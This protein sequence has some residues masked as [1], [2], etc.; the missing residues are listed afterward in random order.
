MHLSVQG[1]AIGVLILVSSISN[2]LSQEVAQC[3]THITD[4]LKD[5]I[6]EMQFEGMAA[7]NEDNG[8]SM[9]TCPDPNSD[10][11]TCFSSYPEATSIEGAAGWTEPFDQTIRII[12]EIDVT[13]TRWMTI[14]PDGALAAMVPKRRSDD[15]AEPVRLIH[16]F[17]DS[18]KNVLVPGESRILF[19]PDGEAL[20]GRD[21]I[22]WTCRYSTVFFPPD[23][24]LTL[25]YAEAEACG[26]RNRPARYD[27]VRSISPYNGRDFIDLPAEYSVSKEGRSHADPSIEPFAKSNASLELHAAFNTG[28]GFEFQEPV[29]MTIPF[30]GDWAT[31]PS[32]RMLVGRIS[33]ED[34]TRQ[35]GYRIRLLTIIDP[36]E[37]DI[38]ASNAGT[39]CLSGGRATVSYDE[40]FVAVH[41]HESSTQAESHAVE[42]QSSTSESVMDGKSSDIWLVDLMNG[43]VQQMTKMQ[44]G[45]FALFP[46]FRSDGWLYF[47]VRDQNRNV[48]Y[49]ATS[50]AAIRL[51][52]PQ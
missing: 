47:L 50:D 32:R 24:A 29:T 25:H 7:I 14:S 30:E 10:P 48:E 26:D 13:G 33:S 28:N 27:Q 11:E 18:K 34:G 42:Q 16:N 12:K 31:S 49:L 39:I 44:P 38:E 2:G 40:R 20:W 3:Q 37:P 17:L 1:S 4:E 35:E 43:R 22:F 45:Q 8:L 21:E 23:D 36:I 51:E 5:Y 6:S 52:K 15:G 41:H 19:N 46:Q 9:F